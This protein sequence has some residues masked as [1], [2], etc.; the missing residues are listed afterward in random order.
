MSV[1]RISGLF[2]LMLPLLLV[3]PQ[4]V[5]A[6]SAWPDFA[7]D[8]RPILNQQCTSRQGG[9]KRAAQ[10]SSLAFQYFVPATV[11]WRASPVSVIW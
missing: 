7:R 5:R 8:I 9:V 2:G 1:R 3:W 11:A 6:A 10:L 4:D